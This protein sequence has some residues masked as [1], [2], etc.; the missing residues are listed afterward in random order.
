M[1]KQ[2]RGA[3]S[4]P[5]EYKDQI[6]YYDSSASGGQ[7]TS[8]YFLLHGLGNSLDFWTDVAPELAKVRR[9]VAI[10]I[11]GFGRS[12]APTSGF[13]LSTISEAIEGFCAA[14][15]IEN[16]VLVAHSLGAFVAMR[17]VA[18]QPA[19]FRRLIL[20]DGTLSRAV[21]LIQQPQR[22]LW[23]P[24]LALYVSAQFIGGVVPI[25]RPA[26]D[27]IGR[28]KLIRRLTLWPYVA[29][30]STLNS[31]IVSDALADNGG[32]DV[33]RVLARASQIDYESL[34]K[35]VLQ[36]VD[37]VWGQCDHL[38]SQ[39][40]V[41][42]ARSHMHVDR[43]LALANCGHWPMIEQPAELTRFLLAERGQ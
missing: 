42:A 5:I 43:E 19:R 13:S 22:M 27:L 29:H 34:M 6:A 37:L 32:L 24:K 15:A 8:S 1:A 14:V 33:I 9:T 3:V 26:A 16:S 21:A 38:I 23:E 17:V 31:N 20:V 40:D 10:D 11:P 35:N 41:Q 2:D 30:P 7:D 28:S 4:L 25:R 12:P 18:N 39:D 36:R